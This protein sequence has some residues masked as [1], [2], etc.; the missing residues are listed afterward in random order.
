[1]KC[2]DCSLPALDGYVRCEK[3][4]EG[5]RVSSWKYRNKNREV[6]NERARKKKQRRIIEGQCRECGKKLDPDIDRKRTCINCAQK[7]RG[8]TKRRNYGIINS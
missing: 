4:L 3:C 6:Y 7:L 2:H 5:D 1:M 8:F